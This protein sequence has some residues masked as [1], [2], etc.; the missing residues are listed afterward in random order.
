[1]PPGR[2]GRDLAVV[3]GL[4]MLFAWIAVRIELSERIGLLTAPAERYQLDEIPYVMLM[5]AAAFAWFAWRRFQEARTALACS[6]AA[7]QRLAA[8]VE[9]NR[10]LIQQSIDAQEAERRVLA[11]DLHDELGQYVNA[12]R[13]DTAVLCRRL[14]AQYPELAR[15]AASI[16]GSARRLQDIVRD[17]VRRLRPVALDELGLQAAIEHFV[18]EWRGRLPTTTIELQCDESSLDGLSEACNL[19]VYRLVQEAIANVARHAQA[20]RLTIMLYRAGADQ[21]DRAGQ[22]LRIAVEDDGQG[23]EPGSIGRDQSRGTGLI[24]MRER[25]EALHGTLTISTRKRS[26][27]RVEAG[28]PLASAM[29]LA[30]QG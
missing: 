18:E 3:V 8:T 15:Q 17:L 22:T 27:F 1:M 29:E 21:G 13:L 9:E 23:G 30:P 19:T 26:G 2:V 24:G 6:F 7:E 20:S 28:I 11:R 10:R 14:A 25:V 5:L 4:T 12:I 16:D